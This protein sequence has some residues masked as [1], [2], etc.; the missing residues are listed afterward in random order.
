MTTLN[1]SISQ[2]LIKYRHLSQ[3]SQEELADLAD[4]HRTYVSQ[5]ERGLKMPTLAILFKIAQALKVKPSEL[6][7]EIERGQDELSN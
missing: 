7:K 6:I 4:I 3:L 1:Q 2:A 5:I